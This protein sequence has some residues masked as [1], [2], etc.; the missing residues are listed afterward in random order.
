ARRTPLRGARLEL[1]LQTELDRPPIARR[2]DTTE[3]RSCSDRRVRHGEVGA[4]EQIE[5]LG[6]ELQRVALDDLELLVH[7]EIDAREARPDHR[8]I[9]DVAEGADR[10]CGERRSLE[11]LRDQ[12]SPWPV[13]GQIWI[14]YQ[15]RAVLICERQ[16]VVPACDDVEGRAATQIYQPG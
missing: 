10:V 9:A 5:E 2:Q 4:V 14:A 13:R 6:T 12:F 3:C 11:V 15:V 16:R 1:V 8:V 7:A